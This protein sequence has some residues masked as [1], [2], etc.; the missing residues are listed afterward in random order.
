A[1]AVLVLFPNCIALA[2]LS[3]KGWTAGDRVLFKREL[4]RSG[5][6]VIAADFVGDATCFFFER[7]DGEIRTGGA[8]AKILTDPFCQAAA[9]F[10][11]RDVDEIMQ[12][13]LAIVPGINANDERVTETDATCVF[14]NDA[15][16]FRRLRQFRI[17][18]E[19]NSI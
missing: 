5:R 2:S 1:P 17:L 7:P 11:L 9:A 19:R 13:Q 8:I 10:A 12:N 4:K 16:A 14:G 3:L 18:R 15:D 6:G